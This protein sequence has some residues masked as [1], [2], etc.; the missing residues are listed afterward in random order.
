MWLLVPLAAALA[1]FVFAYSSYQSGKPPVLQ[2]AAWA[3]PAYVFFL[4][5]GYFDEIYDVAIV[6]PTL[7]LADWLWRTVDTRGI[8]RRVV[9]GARPGVGEDG[10]GPVA[11]RGVVVAEVHR[12]R[13]EATELSEADMAT[14]QARVRARVLKWMVRQGLLEADEA[15][16]I[17]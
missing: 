6:R 9:A 8:D 1:G 3:K 14:V 7:G 13:V 16:A 10:K 17:E 12:E 4:N 5:K 15:R 2:R 11:D